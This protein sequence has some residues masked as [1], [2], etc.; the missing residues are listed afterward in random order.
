MDFSKPYGTLCGAPPVPRAGYTQNDRYFDGAGRLIEE[1]TAEEVAAEETVERETL[2]EVIIS[3]VKDGQSHTDVA[4]SFG[5]SRQKVT[6]IVRRN[7]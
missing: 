1:P 5:I 6:S 4:A 7:S 2:E 3:M